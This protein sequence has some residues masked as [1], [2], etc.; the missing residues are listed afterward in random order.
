M[1]FT[2]GMGRDRQLFAISALFCYFDSIKPFIRN[3]QTLKW[4]KTTPLFDNGQSMNCSEI[5]SMM[6]F[7][8]GAGKYPNLIS[9]FSRFDF[10]KLNDL[11]EKFKEALIQY[12]EYAYMDKNRIDKL[13]NGL[14]M[15]IDKIKEVQK[16]RTKN[17]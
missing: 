17:S 3:V 2:K 1:S 8:N 12:K 13:V 10:N 14:E 9:D 6:N 7:E 16:Q 11:P 5:T 15:R 4:E